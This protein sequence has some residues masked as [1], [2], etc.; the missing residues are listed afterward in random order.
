MGFEENRPLVEALADAHSSIQAVVEG[1]D[2]ELEVYPESGW[3][4]RDILGHIATWDHQVAL[5]LDAYRSGGQYVIP[6]HDEDAFNERDIRRQSDL[7]TEEV[8]RE[9]E[10]SRAEFLTAVGEI[11]PALLPGDL[12]Y[13][14][15]DER[16]TVAYLVE[17]MV[18]HDLEHREAIVQAIRPQG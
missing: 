13:P 4:I 11:P 15:G 18:E 3:R 12:L 14:W 10:R 17:T 8:L 9:W 5:A 1:T 16:G 7:T 6:D 2:L